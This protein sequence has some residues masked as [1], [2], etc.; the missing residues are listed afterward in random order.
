MR[1]ILPILRHAVA[2]QPVNESGQDAGAHIKI[3]ANFTVK[4]LPAVRMVLDRLSM[5]IEE[6]GLTLNPTLELKTGER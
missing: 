5:I 6:G 1:Q 2:I 4:R 3:G